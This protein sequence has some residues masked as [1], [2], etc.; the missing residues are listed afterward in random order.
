MENDKN[1]DK[2]IT[3]QE[4]TSEQGTKPIMYTEEQ[5]RQ[6]YNEGQRSGYISALKQVRSEINDYISDLI[7]AAKSAS[8]N[9]E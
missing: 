3:D 4:N 1:I 8:A 6:M 7:S 5:M 9:K 2:Q